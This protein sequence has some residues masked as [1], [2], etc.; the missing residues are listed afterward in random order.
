M[1]FHFFSS[2]FFVDL[3]STYCLK[4]IFSFSLNEFIDNIDEEVKKIKHEN[5]KNIAKD[6]G[7]NILMAIPEKVVDKVMVDYNSLIPTEARYN[8]S[9]DYFNK[10]YYIDD[11]TR[12]GK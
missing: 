9:I 6:T 5:L 7:K 11:Y 2:Y 8:Q 3:F 4:K 1:F 12:K 10:V